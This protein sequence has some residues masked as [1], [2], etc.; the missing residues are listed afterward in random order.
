[1]KKTQGGF[2]QIF[3][4]IILLLVI[5]GAGTVYLGQKIYENRSKVLAKSSLRSLA[6]G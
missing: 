5:G 3:G 4:L 2:S 1:M 6:Q